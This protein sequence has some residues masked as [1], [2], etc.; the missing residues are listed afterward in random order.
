M[1]WTQLK[2]RIIERFSPSVRGRIDIH[3]TA[4]RR[5]H[6]QLGRGWITIDKQEILGMP[7]ITYEIERYHRV[8]RRAPDYNKAGKEL[9]EENL[10][11]QYDLHQSM[12]DYLNTSVDDILSS[13]NPLIKGFGMLDERVGIRRLQKINIDGEHDLVRR[14]YL[15]RCEAE[16]IQ[17]KQGDREELTSK[18]RI[19]TPLP[20]KVNP[21]R[22]NIAAA[23]KLAKSKKTR[24]VKKLINKIYDEDI[25]ENELD[26]GLS[27]IFYS[28]FSETKYRNTLYKYLLYVEAHSKLLKS[29]LYAQGLIALARNSNDWLRS[30]DSWD[31]PS[32]NPDSQFSS[33]ARHL[34]AEYD[35]PVFMDDAWLSDNPIYQEW[36]RH[37]GKGQNIR[38]AP[39][40]PFPLT[41]S[42]AHY[43]LL[44]PKVYSIP[45]ALRWG[46]V[47]SL[48]GDQRLVDALLDTRLV[49]DFHD[50]DFWES[51]LRFFIRNP[52]LDTIHINPIIDYIWNQKYENRIV[53]VER[54]VANE[55][56]PVQ[57]NFSMKGRTVDSL[58]KAV[59]QWHKTLGKESKSGNFQWK[60]SGIS[61]FK[62]IEGSKE[63][64]NM[65]IWSI[66]ELLN[67]QELVAE[68]REM[69]HCVSSYTQ[70]CYK[71]NSSIWTMNSETAEG[72]EKHLTI[73]INLQTNQ[74][75]QARGKRN[76][77]PTEKE[78]EIIS[79]WAGEANIQMASYI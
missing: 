52:M 23:D 64:K 60:K 56:G 13:D 70:S 21:A 35:V 45:A 25:Q 30:F 36:F 11:S 44:T 43:F 2:K 3:S 22:I 47:F 58:L 4:Y 46:Q 53:F 55:I 40:L 8:D 12:F 34:W 5:M 38:T 16:G 72:R 62:F 17:F 9:N 24:D 74:I 41:K 29:E 59:H 75:C 37:I 39:D 71:G 69:S 77:R 31:V 19:R 66:Q 63:S 1:K 67:S 79:R 50:N 61:E 6:D 76:R 15:L 7:T 48:G 28:G 33:I 49:R 57:P 26:T 54:G 78:R 14:L 51:V 10:F 68:G 42:M 27:K 65:K 73:E 20:E 32:Y 18:L